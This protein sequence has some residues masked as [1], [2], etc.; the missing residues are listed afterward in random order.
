MARPDGWTSGGRRMFW[1]VV[2]GLGAATFASSAS[3]RSSVRDRYVPEPRRSEDFRQVQ[4]VQAIVGLRGYSLGLLF[5]ENYILEAG[6]SGLSR[7]EDDDA[8]DPDRWKHDGFLRLK[9]FRGNSFYTYGG[10]SAEAEGQDVRSLNDPD[11]TTGFVMVG[12]GNQWLWRHVTLGVD[13]IGL[14]VPVYTRVH[15][16]VDGSDGRKVSV[17]S[18]AWA[19]KRIEAF[20]VY[21]GF[22]I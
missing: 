18:D 1:V 14:A 8:A 6:Y 19:D 16:E 13:W 17:R 21:V 15:R 7:Y 9:H 20:K 5:G 4:T 12:I 10:V 3:A 22:A 11:L 2:L